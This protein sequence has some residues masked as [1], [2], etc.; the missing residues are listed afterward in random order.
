MVTTAQPLAAQ[1]GVRML[2]RGGNAVDA[3]LATAIALA[4]VEPVSASIG[5]DAFALIWDG[6]KL[7]GLNASGRSPRALDLS[8]FNRFEEMPEMGWDS[9]TVPGCVSAWAAMSKKFGR[10]PFGDLFQPA[11]EYAREGFHLTPTITRQWRGLFS[12]YK[13]YPE[14]LHIFYPTGRSP[15]IG[16]VFRCREQADTLEV[17]ADT[18][19]EAFYRGTLA[20]KIATHAKTAGAALS[21]DDLATHYA[22]WVEPISIS[23]RGLTLAELPPNGQGLAALIALGILDGL[24]V[25]AFPLESA[26]SIH[27][28]LEAMKLA[29]AD[30]YAHVADPL[31]MVRPAKVFLEPAYLSSLAAKIRPEQ[32]QFPACN[33]QRDG[34]TTYLAAA[35]REGMMVSYIQSNGRGFGSG[36]VV[37]GTGISLQSRGR[38]FT[39]DPSHPNRI[40]PGKRPFH[41]NMPAMAMREG[42]ALAC[43]GLMGWNM[44]PQAHV[45]FVV[46]LMAHRQNPQAILDAPRW[47]I[48]MEEPT[49]LLEPGISEETAD[50]LARRGHRIVKT[51]KFAAASTPYGSAMMFGGAQMIYRLDDGYVGASDGRRDGQAVGF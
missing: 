44:Q 43:F 36:I 5:A 40:S 20:Q 10:L 49:I 14:V 31:H 16:D 29:F 18:H 22:E 30:A 9:V 33:P 46:R 25:S 7:H 32:A 23:Y 6:S 11:I 17:I 45:Q 48:A 15:D 37:P 8:R 12:V 1:A 50:E 26:N 51:E 34:G 42:H 47:R 13:D 21:I 41:T 27:I 19:G 24:D 3:A 35:D 28:Q 2:L 38:S 39:L 4:V